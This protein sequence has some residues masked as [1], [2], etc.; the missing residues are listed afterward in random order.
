MIDRQLPTTSAVTPWLGRPAATVDK[1]TISDGCEPSNGFN[2]TDF[3]VEFEQVSALY[4]IGLDFLSIP[5]ENSTS[6]SGPKSDAQRSCF[7]EMQDRK[8]RAV[9][10]VLA[11]GFAGGFVDEMKPRAGRTTDRYIIGRRTF[12]FLLIQKGLH[13]HAGLWTAQYD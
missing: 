3:N 13:V 8:F 10:L 6:A 9:L 12:V 2:S 5:S 4:W 11:Q 1:C 7:G